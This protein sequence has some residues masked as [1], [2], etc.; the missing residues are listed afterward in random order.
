MDRGTCSTLKSSW[1]TRICFLQGPQSEFI[2]NAPESGTLT[3]V[4]QAAASDRVTPE[5]S[6]VRG[7]VQFH[8]GS[9]LDP[10]GDF[11]PKVSGFPKNPGNEPGPGQRFRGCGPMRSEP[12]AFWRTA[13]ATFS[14]RIGRHALGFSATLTMCHGQ[15]TLRVSKKSGISGLSSRLPSRTNAG[16]PTNSEDFL[17]RGRSSARQ[18]GL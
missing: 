3:K 9:I 4:P 16:F 15:H 17:L 10:S 11:N 14:A 12:R 6:I 18:K 8:R 7:G 1:W 13:L 5:I 2:P